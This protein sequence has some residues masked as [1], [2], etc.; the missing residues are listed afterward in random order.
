MD[1]NELWCNDIFINAS[2]HR[3]GTEIDNPE[4][5]AL[6]FRRLLVVAIATALDYFIFGN[7]I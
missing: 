4:G 1:Q 3:H 5:I 6:C 7:I 2:F